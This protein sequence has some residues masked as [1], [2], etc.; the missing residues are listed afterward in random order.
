[1]LY[2]QNYLTNY[3]INIIRYRN[4]GFKLVHSTLEQTRTSASFS[5]VNR[6]MAQG[7]NKRLTKGGKKGA[8][9]KM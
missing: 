6:N 9:K 4:P 2:G 3:I 7:K 1:M 5:A 8:K